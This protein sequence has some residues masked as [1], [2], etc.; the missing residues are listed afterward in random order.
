MII[1]V[2]FYAFVVTAV[3]Q[4][5]YYITFTS[6]L[7]HKTF[8]KPFDECLPVS[9]IVYA[10]NNLNNLKR[11]I[12]FLQKQEYETYELVLIND[13][14]NDGTLKEMKKFQADD[15]RIKIVNVKN[16][17]AF[18]GNK[19][20]A[21][22]LGIKS[23]NYEQLL[24]TDADC[25][26]NSKKWITEM[27]LLFSDSKS[28]ILGYGSYQSKKYSFLNMLIRFEKLLSTIQYFSYAKIG[29]PIMANGKNLA[30]KKNEFFKVNGFISH[31]KT[32]FGHDNLFI[33]DAGTSS[34]TTIAITKNSFI[35][36]DAPN[37]LK[38]WFNLKKTE[39]NSMAHYKFKH[40]FFLRLFD[41]SKLIFLFLFPLILIFK[42][43]PLSIGVILTYY[44][45]NYLIVGF[46]AKRLLETRML[47][48]LPF[49]E[50]FLV[51][52]Q[53]VIFI[54]NSTSKLANWK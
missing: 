7:L 5:C 45:F 51:L 44:T 16:N 22:T 38:K 34:N 12:P 10:K 13:A 4:F 1:T 6:F 46:S 48:F 42:I 2:L 49:L 27:S 3:I 19:K 21:L 18:W 33:R 31:I 52:F 35:I 39:L 25:I 23:A 8:K 43:D 17:E 37:T 9:V 54:S 50:L 20:Y 28:I 14:S 41:S 47:Y 53:F 36:S 24:F 32:N 29:T 26:P 15:P 11:L 40:K 30:Y